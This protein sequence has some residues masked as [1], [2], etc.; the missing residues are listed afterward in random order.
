MANLSS[1]TSGG[2]IKSIQRG[3]V[4]TTNTSVAGPH[5]GTITVTSVTTSKAVLIIEN[6]SHYKVGPALGGTYGG[7]TYPLP[8]LGVQAVLTNGTTITWTSGTTVAYT[9]D[10]SGNPSYEARVK[11]A[12]TLIEYN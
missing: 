4:D 7:S 9:Y 6:A 3:T 11:F 12:W 10:F 2:G 5:T 8:Y 1:F